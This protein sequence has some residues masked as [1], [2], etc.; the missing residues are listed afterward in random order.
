MLLVWSMQ[1]STFS[2]IKTKTG[3][4][5]SNLISL[6]KLMRYACW[7]I[8]MAAGGGKVDIRATVSKGMQVVNVNCYDLMTLL[9][10]NHK[11]HFEICCHLIKLS[12]DAAGARSIGDTPEWKAWH[13]ALLPGLYRLP[14]LA[15]KLT[16]IPIIADSIRVPSI[17]ES[18]WRHSFV[19]LSMINPRTTS[20]FLR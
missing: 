5:C 9:Y 3:P 10:S 20:Q 12:I 18:V 16:S 17:R 8:P 19:S 13:H 6:F 11:N 1:T 2:H 4:I 15:Q 7:S 14:P